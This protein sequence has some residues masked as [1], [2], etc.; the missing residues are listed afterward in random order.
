MS[1]DDP[2]PRRPLPPG[3]GYVYAKLA[4]DLQERIRSG[5]FPPG[6][7]L[8]GRGVLAAE[9]GVGELT[10]RRAV[11][12]LEDRGAVRRTGSKGALVLGPGHRPGT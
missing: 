9:Y 4:D 10:V 8:P 5:D 12:E 7:R 11:Q 2:P 1:T 3:I 6:G